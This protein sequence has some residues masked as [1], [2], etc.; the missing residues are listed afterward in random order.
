MKEAKNIII[1]VLVLIILLVLV[2]VRNSNQNL[3]KEDVKTALKEIANGNNEI[4]F[5]Q[6]N[7]LKS[8]YIVINLDHENMPDSISINKIISIPI[9]NLLD[10]TSRKILREIDGDLILYSVDQARAAK[11]WVILNQIEMKNLFILSF[12][13]NPE[14]L[15]YKFQPDTTARLEQDSILE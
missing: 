4:S 3:F 9:E 2:V 8:P 6:L 14:E 12:G 10:D 5:N 1:I 13:N 15:K 7:T 11:A